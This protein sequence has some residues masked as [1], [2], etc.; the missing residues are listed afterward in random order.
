[1][2]MDVCYSE[3]GIACMCRLGSV[4]HSPRDYHVPG[5]GLGLMN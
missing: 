5:L 2:Y 4:G 1:M 3:L